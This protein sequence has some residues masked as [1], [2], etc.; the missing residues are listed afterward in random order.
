VQ[1]SKR[2]EQLSADPTTNKMTDSL[3]DRALQLAQ[4]LIAAHASGRSWRRIA[5]EDYADQVHFA[6]LNRIA[7]SGG[8]WLPRSRKILRAL[9]LLEQKQTTPHER[10][11]RRK[12]AKLAKETRER[13]LK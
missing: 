11:V 13:V 3:H 12:I 2:N 4:H 10:R 8:E 6:A 7:L 5:T 9:G 1:A